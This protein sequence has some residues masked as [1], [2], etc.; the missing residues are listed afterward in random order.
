MRIINKSNNIFILIIKSVL[1]SIGGVVF[2]VLYLFL[3]SL[4][5]VESLGSGMPMIIGLF[6]LCCGILALVVGPM[7]GALI[8][9]IFGPMILIFHYMISKKQA[10]NTT[11]VVCAG[12]F[13]AS[14]LIGLYSAGITPGVLQKPDLINTF[15][16]TQMDILK[17]GG[18]KI[19]RASLIVL[20]KRMLQIMP[21][22]LIIVSLFISYVTY[23]LTGRALL[24]RG[25]YI[26]QPSSFIFFRI[27]GGLG[28][29]ALLS[30]VL[31]FALDSAEILNLGIVMDNLY[32][33]F[34]ALFF[35]V[36]LAVSLFYIGRFIK[37]PI[38]GTLMIFLL[39]VIPGLGNI[40]VLIG[41]LDSLFNFRR[42]P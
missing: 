2:P 23:V 8:F 25:N 33:V 6:G 22:A 3:P 1:I 34:S 37:N 17:A 31:I 41:I 40:L 20:Y 39:F 35:F 29:A 10:V 15:I 36:G 18:F 21:A 32:L 4:F 7:V 12:V 38:L 14:L 9:G 26:L 11:I 5:I 28:Q 30:G 42:L 24:K 16:D 19:D 27:P 13:F